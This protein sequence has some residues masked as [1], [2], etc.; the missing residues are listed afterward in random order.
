MYVFIQNQKIAK[1][2]HQHGCSNPMGLAEFREACSSAS[3]LRAMST[4]Y[5]SRG[6]FGVE[7]IAYTRAISPAMGG[8]SRSRTSPIALCRTRWVGGFRDC[9]RRELRNA[10]H[11]VHL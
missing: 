1:D 8:W 11:A 5:P 9:D 10:P 3:E 4:H 7:N 2:G 6:G